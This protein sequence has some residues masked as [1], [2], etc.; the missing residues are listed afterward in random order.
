[1]LSA[2]N[3]LKHLLIEAQISDHLPQLAVL[4]LELLQSTHLDRQQAIVFA[5][6][7]EVGRLT[8]FPPSGRYHQPA[9][10]PNP[11]SGRPKFI[12]SAPPSRGITTKTLAKNDP[13][14][15]AQSTQS[16]APTGPSKV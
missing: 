12:A 15:G 8:D 16:K 10:R 4:I 14:F 3:V 6:P 9:S 1:M 13:V 2:D 11:A 5:L 7:V